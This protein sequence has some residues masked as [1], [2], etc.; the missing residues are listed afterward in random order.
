[1]KTGKC[2][3]ILLLSAVV[4]GGC[5]EDTAQGTIVELKES[6]LNAP[7]KTE[8]VRGDI[9]VTLV[10]D[11]QIG[12]KVEQ[13]TFEEEG[14]FGEFFVQLGDEIKKGEILATPALE[15]IESAIEAKEEQIA[16]LTRTYQYQKETME[17]SILVAQ[18]ELE[19]VQ[20]T[21]EG[22]TYL[23]PEYTQ[24]C[25]Q[26]GNYDEQRRRLELQLKQ[27]TETYELE[28]PYYQKQ[29]R[30]LKEEGEGNM[31][32]APFDG[33]VIA[34]EQLEYGTPLNSNLYYVAVADTSEIYARCLNV[35]ITVLNQVKRIEFWKDGKTYEAISIPMDHDYYMATKNNGEDAYSEFEIMNPAGELEH[36][37]YGK[38]ILVLEEKKDVLLVPETTLQLSGGMYYVYKDVDGKTERVPVEIG[39]KDGIHVEIVEGLEEGDVVYVQE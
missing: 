1:M 5:A 26:A 10:Y 13:L 34:L 30:E 9:S 38:L 6:A 3:A 23:T 17:N 24:A 7:Q 28:L 22:L 19:N 37:D 33:T 16:N 35:S 8:V 20:K 18:K 27:L 25:R 4:L 14:S 31:I 15:G 21:I 36:G 12:P 32:R 29:L 2:L 11:A 39:A